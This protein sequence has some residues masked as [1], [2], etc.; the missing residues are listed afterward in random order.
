MFC[1]SYI[2]FKTRYD[3]EE[4][5]S[6]AKKFLDSNAASVPIIVEPLADSRLPA[7]DNGKFSVDK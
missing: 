5:K 1:K 7:L 6:K 3:I 4:R 2:P